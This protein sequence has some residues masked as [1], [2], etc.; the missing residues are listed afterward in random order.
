M[1]NG[2]YNTGGKVMSG[3]LTNRVALDKALTVISVNGYSTTAI[4]GQWDSVSTN[5]PGAVRCAWLASGALLNGFTLRNGATRGG[6]L[7]YD[8]F[9]VEERRCVAFHQR[10]RFRLCIH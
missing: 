6:N 1:T 5:G 9:T 2:V 7:S 8:R 4:E 10:A 3:D